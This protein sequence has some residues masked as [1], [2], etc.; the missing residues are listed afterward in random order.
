MKNHPLL[1]I[2][3]IVNF[4][5]LIFTLSQSHAAAPVNDVADVL[6]GRALQIVDDRGRVRASI[7]VL[8]AQG[9]RNSEQP[10]PETVLLRLITEQGRPSV[11]VSASEEGAGLAFAGPTGTTQTYAQLMAQGTVSSLKLKNEDGREELVKPD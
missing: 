11:K 2:L 6:R 1:W 8:P 4:V 5:M 7:S 10:Y 9:G 3:T